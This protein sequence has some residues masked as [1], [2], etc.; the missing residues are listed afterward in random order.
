MIKFWLITIIVAIA[1]VFI[2]TK[3]TIKE[4]KK[5]NSEKMWKIWGMKSMYYQGVVFFSCVLTFIIM[6]VLNW[7]GVVTY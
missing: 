7:T 1:L 5:E 2:L 6:F 4:Y 3:L